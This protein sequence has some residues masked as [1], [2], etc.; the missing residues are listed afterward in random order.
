[1]T[2]TDKML[3]DTLVSLLHTVDYDPHADDSEIMDAINWHDIRRA[4]ESAQKEGDTKIN[5]ALCG[6]IIFCPRGDLTLVTAGDAL[7]YIKNGDDG[8]SVAIHSINRE[9]PD[10]LAEAWATHGELAMAVKG[11][12]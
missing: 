11:E 6:D 9:V 5:G 1:M 8:V 7:V 12:G 4:V 2:N 10:S 3:L